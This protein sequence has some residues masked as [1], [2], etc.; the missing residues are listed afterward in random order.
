MYLDPTQTQIPNFIMLKNVCH[1]IVLV[2][3]GR[4]NAEEGWRRGKGV[5]Q[6]VTKDGK[7][8]G[9]WKSL[10]LADIIYE[11]P[12]TLMPCQRN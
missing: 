7:G 4:E 8:A 3:G 10:K 6:K 9:V 12:L 2:K 1:K 11:Q 5:S